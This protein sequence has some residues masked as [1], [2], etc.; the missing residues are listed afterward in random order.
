[1]ADSVA[2]VVS[3]T[4]FD[5]G[6]INEFKKGI[7]YRDPERVKRALDA[8]VEVDTPVKGRHP[9]HMLIGF[10]H[11]DMPEDIR[12]SI[13]E[14]DFEARTT[15]IVNMLF[16]H[17]A[18]VAEPEKYTTRNFNVLA[19]RLLLADNL[20]DLS[21]VVVHAIDE[22]LTQGGKPYQ[23]DP[24]KVIQASLQG[25][26]ENVDIIGH[27]N[28]VLTAL[29]RLHN[30]VVARLQNPTSDLEK[31]IVAQHGP[32]VREFT[33]PFRRPPV[34]SIIEDLFPQG[35]VPP[36][37][38]DALTQM[39]GAFSGRGRSSPGEYVTQIEKK[40]AQQVLTEIKDSFVGLTELKNEARSLVFRQSFDA[41]TKDTASPDRVYGEVIMGNEGL[42]KSEFLRKK[43]ELLVALDLAGDKYVEFSQRN[44]GAASIGLPPKALAAIFAQAD[45]IN[46]EIP[47]PIHDGRADIADFGKRL[48]GALQLSL[49]G[50]E[51]PPVLFLSGKP[52]TIGEILSNNPALKPLIG[53][54]TKLED[55]TADD[56]SQI[57]ERK[58]K[59]DY[60]LTIDND[61]REYVL[62]AIE[63]TR[64]DIGSK[65]FTNAYEIANMPGEEV[66]SRILTLVDVNALNLRKILAGP[67]LAKIPSI[68][69]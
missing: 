2:P 22:S 33:K 4:G 55:M 47:E 38:D 34:R 24:K 30:T 14:D 7:F 39:S 25:A 57:L 23:P 20:V 11:S 18:K 5:P 28:S 61:A 8:K 16:D 56:L 29:E 36:E 6:M 60:K 21:T 10:D 27:V 42:G 44:S 43:A 40:T 69:F 51:K 13:S 26:G 46:L 66:G 62:K 50:R 9:L 58:L 15:A 49:E 1:M 65:D 41:V 64:K 54:Y 3:E 17:G 31:Q 52:E 59:N 48:I 63:N 53:G 68:G 12:R 37:V 35:Q 67:L 32:Q 19:D 45:I